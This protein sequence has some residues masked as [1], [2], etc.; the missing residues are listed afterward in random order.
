MILE[1]LWFENLKVARLAKSVIWISLIM[2]HV[3]GLGLQNPE[4]EIV[5]QSDIRLVR[6]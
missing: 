3:V 2:E 6:Y 1:V 5:F 4:L